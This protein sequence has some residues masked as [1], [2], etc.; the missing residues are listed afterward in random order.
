VEGAEADGELGL[1]MVIIPGGTFMMGTPEEEEE[2]NDRERPQHEVT[3]QPFFMS[4][5]PITQAQWRAV[6]TATITSIDEALRFADTVLRFVRA[7]GLRHVERLVLKG[8]WNQQTYRDMASEAGYTEIYLRRKVGTT[9]WS[10]LSKALG[11]HINKEN[12]RSEVE[13]WANQ[14]SLKSN[15]SNFEGDTL[16]VEQVSWEDAQEFCRRLSVKTGKDYRLPSEAEWEY[17]CRAGTTTAYH[18]GAT[19]PSELANH[20]FEVSQT[21]EV[22]RY[23]A[24]YWG[25]YDM[26]GNVWEWCQDR[27][28]ETY[29][30]APTDGSAWEAHDDEAEEKRVLRGGSWFF[31]PE[32]CR[33]AVRVGVAPDGTDFG[34]GFRVVCGGART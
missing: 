15:P 11:K 29:E 16:P 30:G 26:H 23:P 1:E 32:G 4:R 3:L 27:W 8:T 14:H 12:F 9:L 34:V 19:L 25:L 10:S 18:F 31:Y 33:S 22:G 5:H 2:G 24:N 7:D 6:A 28:H 20:S 13:H 17:A 21:S